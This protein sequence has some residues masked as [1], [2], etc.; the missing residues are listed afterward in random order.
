M[1][2][3]DYDAEAELFP[4][5]ARASRRQPVGYRR[6]SRAAEAIRFAI[7]ELPPESLAGA[8]LEVGEERFDSRAMRQLYESPDYPLARPVRNASP[9]AAAAAPAREARRPSGRTP[10]EGGR[11]TG[12]SASAPRVSVGAKKTGK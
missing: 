8:A 6:F 1:R 12:S 11:R 4:G 10:E 3:F 9:N 7:E 2:R 5:F